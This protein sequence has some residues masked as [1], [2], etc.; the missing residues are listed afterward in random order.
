[1]QLP[2]GEGDGGGA[3]EVGGECL[4]DVPVPLGGHPDRLRE[5]V[6]FGVLADVPQRAGLRGAAYQAGAAGGREHEEGGGAGA[7]S[8]AQVEEREVPVRGPRFGGVGVDDAHVGAGDSIPLR[9][10]APRGRLDAQFRIGSQC[11][12]E[13]GA[14]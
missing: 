10:L 1:M 14:Q 5:T 4:V 6:G 2:G 3:D 9:C 8:A 11:G 12:G 13:G 7:Q